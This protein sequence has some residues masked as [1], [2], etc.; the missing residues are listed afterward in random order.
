MLSFALAFVV[1]RVLAAANNILLCEHR[2]APLGALVGAVGRRTS[3]LIGFV[4]VI[5]IVFYLLAVLVSPFAAAVLDRSR[6]A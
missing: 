6:K 5:V 2:F 4:V 1:L 3:P